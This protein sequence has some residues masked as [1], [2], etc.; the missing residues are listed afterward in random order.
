M[1]DDQG[2]Y[3]E[4][5]LAALGPIEVGSIRWDSSP[6]EVGADWLLRAPN[7]KVA[8][9]APVIAATPFTWRDPRSIPPRRFIYDKHY[10]RQFPS[11]TIAPGGVGKS[12]LGIAEALSMVSGRALLGIKPEQR[13]RV[14]LW[15]GEDPLEELERRVG[16]AMVHYG[17]EPE[18]VEG[19]LFLDSGRHM[20]IIIAEQTRDGTNISHPTVDQVIETIRANKIDVLIIDPFVSSHRVTENDNNAIERVVKTWAAIADETNCAIDLVHHSRKTGGA[21]VTVEDS[22]GASALLSAARSARA[23]NGMTKEEAEKFGLDNRRLYFRVDNGK[24]NL[25]APMDEA[26]WF[27]LASVPL[28]NGSPEVPGD[29]VGVVTEWKPPKPFDNVKVDDLRKVQRIVAE[30]RW[31]ENVQAKNWVGKAVAQV[32]N[33]DANNKAHRSKISALLKAWMA[34]G[35][36]VIVPGLDEQRRERTFVGVGEW[37]ND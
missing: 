6:Q 33:L 21:E 5:A 28:G 10:I 4:E 22:R 19:W 18:A 3:F 16:A 14:W 8:A 26:A 36:L 35:A 13:V 11:A 17:L 1:M 20:P 9:P 29:S 24:A 12:S 27:K 7:E 34:N 31:R 32:L 15:N 2:D 23:L 30:G 25:V 37:A